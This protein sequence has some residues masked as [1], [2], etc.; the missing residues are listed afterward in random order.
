MQNYQVNCIALDTDVPVQGLSY[1]V[2]A[3]GSANAQEIV[4]RFFERRGWWA[5][6][7]DVQSAD[8]LLKQGGQLNYLEPDNLR[9]DD[10]YF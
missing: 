2:T 1:V 7:L 3:A 10:N 5:Y 8:D 9:F 6:V 4:E